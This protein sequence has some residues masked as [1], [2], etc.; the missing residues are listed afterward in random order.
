MQRRILIVFGL[1]G[2]LAGILVL[3]VL[4]GR[5]DPTPRIEVRDAPPAVVPQPLQD[6][7]LVA[8]KESG[9]LRGKVVNGS[10]DDA[11]IEG[12][13][14][15]ALRPYLE[16]GTD[17]EVPLWGQ[18]EE[19]AKL[20]TAKDG[21]FAIED[22]GPD[23]WN[24]WVEKPGYA[25]TTVPR[26]KFSVEHVIRLYPACSLH[27]RVVYEDDTPAAGVRLEYTPQGTNSE[28]F[29]HLPG[30]GLTGYYRTTNDDGSFEYRDLPPGKFT[31]EVYPED[32][33]PAPWAFEPPLVPGENRDLG[34]RKLTR[35]FG[36]TV[37]VK[38]RGSGAPV[39]GVEVTVRPIGDPMPRTKTGRHRFTDANGVA[40]FGGLG[41]Q[42]LDTPTFQ[43]TANIG[44]NPVTPDEQRGF[45]PEEDVTIWVRR[46]SSVKGKVLRPNG[47]P[48]ERFFVELEPK[49]FMTHQIRNWGENG[50]F[51]LLGVPEGTYVLHVRY[52]NLVDAAID[53]EAKAGE[54]VD[55]GTVTL[56]EGGEVYGTVRMAS[57]KALE[58]I[59]KV[60]LARKIMDPLVK[61][62]TW[63]TVG[64]A[65]CKAD[66]TYRI[67]GI[68]P[69][70]YWIWPDP[71]QASP[72]TPE[73]PIE[74]PGGV[75]SVQRDLEV[76]GVAH[77]RLKFMDEVE[78]Q[79][80]HVTQPPT[81][82]VPASGG[83]EI[84]WTGEGHPLRPG[85]YA[86]Y[87]EILDPD[88]VSKRY[89]AADVR[90]QEGETAD[91]IE[92]RLYEIRNG[93]E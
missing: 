83:E 92:V 58:G 29:S 59:V 20:R 78:G 16:R 47:N 56:A 42:T 69:G 62:E 65:Y 54:E 34:V 49:G 36:M 64:R 7:D 68:P 82:L 12:A 74:M 27:G 76:F 67:K 72:T 73:L 86:V 40:R 88:G 84:R 51:K 43:V 48:L 63:E 66:G 6:P 28:V 87:V 33:L 21:S 11:P 61:R 44:G 4:L 38:Q 57:G 55:V 60:H 25:W 71:E 24:L 91:P 50:E 14:V 3:V 26:A 93:N 22:L 37:H 5:S 18:L 70:S 13:T 2:A 39:E 17:D 81:W 10:A 19:R 41:G 31:V 32:H 90:I 79:V 30:R 1:L 75:G 9:T 23:Y 80:R 35:G 8:R 45:R 89:K 53:V 46:E 77:L 85:D 15:I 52:G